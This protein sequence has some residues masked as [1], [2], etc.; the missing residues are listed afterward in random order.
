MNPPASRLLQRLN[1]A[2]AGA[3]SQFT[4]DCAYAERACYLAR[5][6]DFA[7]ASR[8]IRVLRKRYEAQPDATMSAWLNLAEGLVS[9]FS[10]LGP[11]AYDKVLRAHALSAATGLT[12]LNALAAAW[13]AQMSFSRHDVVQ[14]AIRASE[15]LRL[16]ESDH[17]SARSRANLVVAQALHVAGRSD[18]AAP[19]YTRAR[20]HATAEG[21]E[22]TISALMHNMVS[23]RL[24]NLRQ[25]VLTGR[26]DPKA[27][28][29]SLVGLD[30]SQN[31]D[32]LVGTSTLEALR[33]MMRARFLSLQQRNAEALQIYDQH[34]PGAVASDI[35]RMASDVLSDIAWCRL[36]GR[37]HSKSPIGSDR[38]GAN[39]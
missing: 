2:I 32:L 19:W 27:A 25:S 9:Y 30:S 4:C 29:L 39:V 6:G 12:R 33:P 37:R 18:L 13:L 36:K 28:D 5:Q 26:G 3:K 22:L 11:G 14:V 8:T 15:A 35:S 7:E 16:S 38:G 34:F 24:D 10:E 31:F 21:D 23:M 17:H 20:V 1:A